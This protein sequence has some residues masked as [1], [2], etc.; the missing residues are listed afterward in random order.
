ME[1]DP[2]SLVEAF[3]YY[4]SEVT[5][6]KR[7]STDHS[8][9]QKAL[10]EFGYQDREFGGVLQFSDHRDYSGEV[11]NALS[12]LRISGRIELGQ[13][14]YTL[15]MNEIDIDLPPEVIER[16][17]SSVERIKDSEEFERLFLYE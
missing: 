4:S 10:K 16:V 12:I 15:K 3:L 7:I 6:R 9:I 2:I 14:F 5:G 8:D 11:E 13:G 1:I 17:K